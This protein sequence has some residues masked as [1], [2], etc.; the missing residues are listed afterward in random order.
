M[1]ILKEPVQDQRLEVAEQFLSVPCLQEP[2][3]PELSRLINTMLF[4]EL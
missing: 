1:W 2:S 4:I 3:L